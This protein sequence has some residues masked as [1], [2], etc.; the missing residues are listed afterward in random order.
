MPQPIHRKTLS[1]AV[2]LLGLVLSVNAQKGDRFNIAIAAFTGG[3]AQLSKNSGAISLSLP[4]TTT[5]AGGN[6]TRGI[7]TSQPKQVYFPIRSDICLAAIEIGWLRYFVKGSVSGALE[8]SHPAGFREDVGLGL[9]WPVKSFIIKTSLHLVY[10]SDLGLNNGSLIG[11]LD[12][13][14]RTVHVLGIDAGPT[15]TIPPHK[16]HPYAT[17][18][19]SAHADLYFGQSELALLPMVSVSNN[20]R[21]SHTRLELDAGY[22]IPVHDEGDIM[23]YQ[24]NGTTPGSGDRMKTG[25]PVNIHRT[26]YRIGGPYISFVFYFFAKKW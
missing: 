21:G 22:S 16:S 24:D 6:S 4:Y 23:V 8:G 17:T 26:P 7:F 15:F 18:Y 14:D 10:N 11:Y 19:N 20:P 3:G 5:D 25:G 13:T 9:N 2:T 12:N 1:L